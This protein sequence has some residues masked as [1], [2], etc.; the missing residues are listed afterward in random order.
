MLYVWRQDCSTSRGGVGN[1][2]IWP[3]AQT[4]GPPPDRRRAGRTCRKKPQD[5]QRSGECLIQYP[6]R[7]R[8]DAYSSF[9]RVQVARDAGLSR[10]ISPRFERVEEKVHS[11]HHQLECHH[12]NVKE[13][14]SVRAGMGVWTNRTRTHDAWY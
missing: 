12:D 6:I 3:S 5:E 7:G 2:S 4:I 10:C 9:F 14:A 13:L 1:Y 8:C 11:N